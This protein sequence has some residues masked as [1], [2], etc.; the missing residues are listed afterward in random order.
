MNTKLVLLAALGAL[1]LPF[2]AHAEDSELDVHSFEYVDV[3]E[4]AD[5]SIWKGVVVEQTPN[6][7]YKIATADGSLHVIQAADVVKLTK[8]KNPAWAESQSMTNST[9]RG[10]GLGARFDAGS[11]GLPAPY[12]SSGLRLEPE[13]TVVFPQGVLSDAKTNTSF[14]AGFRVG[15]EALF[16]NFGLSGGEQT[17]VTWWGL[18]TDVGDIAW[19]LETMLYGRA[20]LHISRAAPYVGV[21]LGVDTNYIYSGVLGMSNTSLGFGMDVQAGIAIAATKQVAIDIGADFHPGTDTL[22]DMATV[23]SSAEYLAMHVGASIR[24]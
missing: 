1:A 24:L 4:T 14:G 13:S 2:V 22:N 17:R 9:S 7:Q 10:N 23:K 19:T 8:Q 20:A 11:G 16:G 12:A 21:A 3:I 6:V 5:G 15:Y 18:P